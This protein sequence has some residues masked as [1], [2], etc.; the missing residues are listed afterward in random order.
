[1]TAQEKSDLVHVL[2]TDHREVEQAF[3]QLESGVMDPSQRGELVAHVITELVRH[4]VAEE[5]Y[6]YPETRKALQ[7]GDQIAD[8]ELQ[9]H[10]EAER[11]M[12]DL[13]R[14]EAGTAEFEELLARLK[15]AVRDHVHEEET[16]L[17]PALASAVSSQ[18]LAELGEAVQRAKAT[19]PTR[20]HPMSPKSGTAQKILAPGVGMI[21]RM[22]D[23]IAG[24]SR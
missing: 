11:I 16:E 3:Q 14:A 13:E 17:L 19:A 1:M 21:D 12:K 5:Q 18:R 4:S 24:R 9:E 2:T 22:R 7:D 10:A 23:A 20:P 6:L 15:S 8:R